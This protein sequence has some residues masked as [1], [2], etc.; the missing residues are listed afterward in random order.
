MNGSSMDANW[1]KSFQVLTRMDAGYDI[2]FFLSSKNSLLGD[3]AKNF[4]TFLDTVIHKCVEIRLG[5]LVVVCTGLPI[6]VAFT[7]NVRAN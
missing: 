4:P 3:G 6:M 7:G 5:V 1:S 2:V